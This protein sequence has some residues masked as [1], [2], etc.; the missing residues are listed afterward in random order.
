ME[1]LIE[2]DRCSTLKYGVRAEHEKE[3]PSKKWESFGDMKT[4]VDLNISSGH[5]NYQLCRYYSTKQ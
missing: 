1:N 2:S 3:R 5:D 4:L